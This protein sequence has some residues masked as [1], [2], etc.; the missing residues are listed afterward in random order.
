MTMTT[1]AETQRVV[2]GGVDTHSEVHVVAAVDDA[3]RI[4]DTA[5]FPTTMAGYRGL[6][7]WLADRGTVAKV[8]VEGTGSWG[9]GLTRYLH[10]QDVEV[11]EVDRP[12][13]RRR[14]AR[15]KS[16]PVDAEAAARAALNGEATAIPRTKAGSVEAIRA[17]RVVRRSAMRA[18]IQTIHQLQALVI[19]APEELRAL[20]DDLSREQLVQTASRMRVG[21]ID[22]ILSAHKSAMKDLARRVQF[23]DEQLS[24][25]DVSISNLVKT[26]CPDVLE[27]F[28]VGPDTASILLVTL[29]DNP[30]RLRSE[31]AFARL[32]GVAPLEASSGKTTRHRLSRGGDRQANHAL[33]RIV[34]VRM[35]HHEQTRAYVERRRAEGLSTKEIMRCLKRYVAREV[36]AVILSARAHAT[37]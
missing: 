26:T 8:G 30:E 2:F 13:R 32:C 22:D 36:Y 25:V 16:D 24:G 3:G 1:F 37:K 35:A 27:L 12:D 14:R 23:L 4:L 9:A 6:L 33:W 29:G 19:T 10:S 21:V 18:R 7:S 11:V 31:A 5:S 15:G 28:G 20:L 34:L 17:L